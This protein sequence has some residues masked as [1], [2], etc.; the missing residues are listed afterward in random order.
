MFK[1]KICDYGFKN[2]K[3]LNEHKKFKHAHLPINYSCKSD[4]GYM[5]PTR[6][7]LYKHHQVCTKR[8]KLRN[9][10]GK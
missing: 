5:G 1:C 8:N 4:C 3:C 2:E 9:L 7:S 10:N 6:N